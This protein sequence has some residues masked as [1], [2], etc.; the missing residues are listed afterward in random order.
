MI[1]I[2]RQQENIG[3]RELAKEIGISSSTLSRV[4]NDHTCDG[5]TMR[6]LIDFLFR[7]EPE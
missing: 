3:V 7:R 2:W 5:E 4:E 6:L 1:Q